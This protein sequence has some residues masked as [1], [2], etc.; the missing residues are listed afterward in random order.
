M[1]TLLVYSVLSKWLDSI[2]TEAVK[3]TRATGARSL[4]K[5]N[6]ID[7]H[8]Y[9]VDPPHIICRTALYL[10]RGGQLKFLLNATSTFP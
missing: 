10:S 4:K 1:R 5:N 6:D 2:H 7:G 9:P 8:P 3:A